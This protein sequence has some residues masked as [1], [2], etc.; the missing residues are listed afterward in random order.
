MNTAIKATACLAAILIGAQCF[1]QVEIGFGYD[2]PRHR[3]IQDDLTKTTK[4]RS[5][6]A[7]ISYTVPVWKDLSF[8]AGLGYFPEWGRTVEDIE[9]ISCVEHMQEH[10][11]MLPLHFNW[12]VTIIPE[13]ISLEV[14][15]GPSLSA[16]IVSTSRIE[17]FG[18]VEFSIDTDNFSGDV[19]FRDF[20]YGEDVRE[21]L[22]ESLM[23]VGMRQRRFDVMMG[24]GAGLVIRELLSVRIGYDFGLIDRIS[25][26]TERNFTY[27][28]DMMHFGIGFRF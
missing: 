1:G 2:V 11:I 9:P 23:D 24:G 3:I 25:A 18:A 27:R 8:T 5:M 16:G 28:K 19:R 14:F 12:S 21:E 15:A 20:R 6:H 4:T 22:L 17:V 10:T 13:I 7:G 26:T